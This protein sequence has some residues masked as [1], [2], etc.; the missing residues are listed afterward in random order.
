MRAGDGQHEARY[1]ALRSVHLRKPQ[2]RL[3]GSATR[4]TPKGGRFAAAGAMAIID[5]LV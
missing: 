2:T 3:R 5:A 1:Q 4:K